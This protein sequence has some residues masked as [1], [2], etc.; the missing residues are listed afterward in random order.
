M[1]DEWINLG[2]ACEIESAARLVSQAQPSFVFTHSEFTRNLLE[3][4]YAAG[5]DCYQSVCGSLS[6]TAMS[7]TRSRAPGQ[8]A[9]RDVALR[10]QAKA[11]A[12]E[13]EASTPVHEF[14]ASLSA[15]A[16]ASIERDRLRDEESFE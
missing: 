6:G 12:S 2:N 9:P 14:Y 15:S 4:A 3:R 16:E 5:H 7:G 13:F 1:L 11:V 10:D 8:A